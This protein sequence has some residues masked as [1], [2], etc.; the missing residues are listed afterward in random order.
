LT[1]LL[2][3]S[4]PHGSILCSV[5]AHERGDWDQID[6]AQLEQQGITVDSMKCAYQ[7]SIAWSEAS[8]F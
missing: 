2:E 3:H 8:R 1:G 7:Q 4:G 6:W 5:L